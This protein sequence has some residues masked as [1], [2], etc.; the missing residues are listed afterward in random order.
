MGEMLKESE[1]VRN[2][3]EEINYFAVVGGCCICKQTG[4]TG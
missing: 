2:G 3:G 1:R 4:S